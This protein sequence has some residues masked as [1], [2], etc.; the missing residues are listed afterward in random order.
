MV[1]PPRSV[2][3][4]P[5]VIQQGGSGSLTCA[6]T[7]TRPIEVRWL[8]ETGAEIK[9]SSTYM[10]TANTSAMMSVLTISNASY[11]FQDGAI[12]CEV[13]N[14]EIVDQEQRSFQASST[15]TVFGEL[16]TPCNVNVLRLRQRGSCVLA[17]VFVSYDI[18]W[19]VASPFRDIAHP[20]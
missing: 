11:G 15:V 13:M 19:S 6:Y 16:H 9:D 20:A 10:V 4:Q 7:G 3:S 1:V 18:A 12:I 14:S 17:I 5:L 2:I 8:D